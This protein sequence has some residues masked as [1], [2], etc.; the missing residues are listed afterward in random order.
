MSAEIAR[1]EAETTIVNERRKGTPADSAA[2]V[3]RTLPPS[4]YH[5]ARLLAVE[6]QEIFEKEWLCIGRTDQFTKP[7]QYVTLE[8]A[9]E[10][11]IV[12]CDDN[13]CIRA[14]SNV[15]RH[16]GAILA[17]GQGQISRLVCP[18][19]AW[20]YHTDGTLMHAPFMEQSSG[21]DQQACRLPEFPVETWQGF[22]FVTLNTTPEP[23][24][25]R[26]AGLAELVAPYGFERFHS[27]YEEKEVWQVNWKCMT[28]NAIESYHVFKAHRDSIEK[29]RPTK[30]QEFVPCGDAYHVHITNAAKDVP[31]PET[32]YADELSK[33]QRQ[34]SLIAVVYPSSVLILTPTV[35][36]WF[37]VQPK[38]TDQSETR[39]GMSL[40]HAIEG[41]A[42]KEKVWHQMKAFGDQIN[43]E[44]RPVVEG[45][46]SGTRSRFLSQSAMSHL[47]QPVFEF[48]QY[49]RARLGNHLPN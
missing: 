5:D 3:A 21:F 39:Y 30:D 6:K 42:A 17:K 8:I 44:D 7:G 33:K 31:A 20:T 19:H 22:V 14:F 27:A 16:R 29:I 25:P 15:C 38:S 13:L 10:P 35:A 47:E 36:T 4:V 23:L 41:E 40:P 43:G 48:H 26:L 32:P 34:Q 45:V 46:H 9:D 24:A 18:Y 11:L 12:L 37:T 49:L 28:E 1:P 2:I